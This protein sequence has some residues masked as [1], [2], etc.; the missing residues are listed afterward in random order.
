MAQ[1]RHGEVLDVVRDDVVA[2]VGERPGLRGPDVR[3]APARG[4]PE[5]D[6]RVATGLLGDM[7][8][9]GQDDRVDVTPSASS[10]IC[11]TVGA[12]MTGSI[13]PAR[14]RTWAFISICTR[15]VV[16]GVADR[17][18]HQEPV[19]LRLGQPVGAGLLDGVL[20]GDH[21]EGPAHR[22]GR[23]RRW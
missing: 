6:L 5:L 13:A 18:L 7:R 15:R 9:V 17:R 10:L 20:G 11:A 2:A 23:R 16:V 1:H 21:H 14:S 3:Q 22:V 12:V 4:Q 8:D 19:E